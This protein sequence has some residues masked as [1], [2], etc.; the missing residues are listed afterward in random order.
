[1]TDRHHL[2]SRLADRELLIGTWQK[3][4]SAIVT[5]VLGLTDLDLVV[6]DAEHA[7]FGPMEL[8]ACVAAARA[9][10]LPAII[11]VPTSQPH[12][13]LRALDVGATGVLIPHVF[14]AAHAE[15]VVKA[16]HFGPGGRGYAGSTRAAEYTLRSMAVHRERSATDTVVIVQ[17]EDAD[18]LN[19]A[20]TIAA[21]DGVDAIFIGTVDLSVSMGAESPTSNEVAAAVERLV[22]GGQ[23]AG[24]AVG[25]FT[26]PSQAD[27]YQRLGV[28]LFLM[29]SDQTFLLDG[30]RRLL[31]RDD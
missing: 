17:I 11:R 6:L 8:D 5:E 12:H 20:E 28:S 30:A 1:M 18:A 7:P 26:T 4:P 22:A 2:K 3:T 29:Q 15:A 9:A 23:R 21:V 27:H 25:M 14:T 13:I 16:A 19:H 10:G 24:T 31:A